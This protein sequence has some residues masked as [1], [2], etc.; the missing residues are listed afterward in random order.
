MEELNW[1]QVMQLSKNGSPKPSRRMEKTMS[2]WE[3][4]LDPDVFYVTRDHGTERPFS[5][6]MCSA[7]TAG[8]YA[9]ACCG[10]T[11]FDS[12]DKFDSGSGW[13]SFTVPVADNSINYIHDET[14]GMSRIEVQCNVCDAHLGHVFPDGP[15]PKGLRYCINGISLKKQD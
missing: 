5:S 10:E 7:H 1:H 14:H 3:M 11:L 4:E 15:E 9:C 6:H 8:I 2:D 12:T 13:P